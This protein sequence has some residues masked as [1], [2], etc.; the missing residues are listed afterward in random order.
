M[1]QIIIRGQGCHF[2]SAREFAEEIERTT[3]Q[4]RE[5]YLEKQIQKKQYL[6]DGLDEETISKLKENK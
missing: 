2:M 1:E 6:L 5:E 3:N 4:L